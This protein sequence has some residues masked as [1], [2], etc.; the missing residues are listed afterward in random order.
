[1]GGVWGGGGGA[2]SVNG[3]SGG[4]YGGNGGASDPVTGLG[5]GGGG[6]GAAG[7]AIFV[8]G[9]LRIG[10]SV[11]MSSNTL[12]A[13]LGGA[14]AGTSNNGGN[15]ST[16]GPDVLLF[17]SATATFYGDN[18]QTIS[19]GLY[20]DPLAPA[21]NI[22]GGIIINL[23]VPASA[24]TLSNTANSY[25][26]PTT[27]T[28]G[29][30]KG[31]ALNVFGSTSAL[32]MANTATAIFDLNGFN[33]TVGSLS[34][35]GGSGGNIALG[36]NT[37]T[38]NQY[39]AGTYS[40]A[41]SGTGGL[42]L[43]SAS[44]SALTLQ[45]I[46][47]SGATTINGGT[48][49][50]NGVANT[51]SAIQIN[52][53]GTLTIST[54]SST[55]QS[56]TN[57]GTLNLVADLNVAIST[58]I[59]S[60]GGGA[61][62]VSGNRNIGA[63][64]YISSGATNLT[65]T[66]VGVN[67]SLT[68]TGNIILNNGTVN[69]T[70]NYDASF[71]TT[72][73]WTLIEAPSISHSATV[74]NVPDTLFDSWSH[75]NFAGNKLILTYSRGDLTVAA[76]EG[77]NMQIATAINA[78][79]GTTPD[80]VTLLN[81]FFTSQSRTDFNNDL[82]QMLPNLNAVAPNIAVQNA[83]FTKVETRMTTVRDDTISSFVSGLNA[84]DVC[85]DTAVWLGAFGSKARQQVIGD[86]P[87]YRSNSYG[88][89][90]GVDT[91]RHRG[92]VYGFGLAYSRT[93]VHQSTYNDVVTAVDGYHAL[94]YGSMPFRRNT[95]F[96]WIVNAGFNNYSG[97]RAINVNGVVMST[98]STYNG[99]QAG[100][101][102]NMGK[103][104]YLPNTS[105]IS[106]LLMLQYFVT[107]Q[108]SYDESNSPAALHVQPLHFQNILTFGGGARYSFPATEQWMIDITELRA[109]VTY[110]VLTSDNT[111]SSNFLLGS[112]SFVVAT[113]PKRW[114]LRL[115]ADVGFAITKRSNV[116]FSYDLELR[117]EYYDNAILLKVAYLF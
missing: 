4:Y 102:I 6:G 15:G 38:V 1:M 47:Y 73:T 53:G 109:L 36:A 72:N 89:I 50:F 37:L 76:N 79:P 51:T 56:I 108:P 49:I 113:T 95:F 91:D 31:G 20:G 98:N 21:A 69:I 88:L 55:S 101:R 22:D 44:T 10:D 39:V 93:L 41:F 7:G 2:G 83:V 77:V 80:Q 29:T 61:V 90:L 96:E 59:T 86:N 9:A 115:G 97:S 54:P 23:N 94:M 5:G 63:G 82:Q 35:G 52:S 110:D 65:I 19:F 33:Q 114:A 104:Y 66:T 8:A 78:M 26:G 68:G 116:Q 14:G 105:R 74:V 17:Q 75:N 107:Y 117:K 48:L 92:G 12:T 25:R 87:G 62:N 32:V 3:G 30:L 57:M 13:G 67:D 24:I 100:G 45:A 58:N 34:G 103:H 106:P 60:S 28:A 84:G 43:S 111:V 42:T 64:D 112:S 46:G 40:G 71:T 81:A 11:S 18:N 70:S 85:P 16:L 99:A 27:V